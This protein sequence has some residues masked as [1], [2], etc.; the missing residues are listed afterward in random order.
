MSASLS[1]RTRELTVTDLVELGFS[2]IEIQKLAALR[3]AYP[4]VEYVESST[5]WSRL[6]FLK[7]RIENGHLQRV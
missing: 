1:S 4:F 5:Q 6:Q 2:E 3:A 7:W